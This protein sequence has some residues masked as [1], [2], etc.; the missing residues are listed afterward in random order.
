VL[1]RPERIP[2][3]DCGQATPSGSF[4]FTFYLGTEGRYEAKAD[5]HQ[6]GGGYEPPHT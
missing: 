3:R 1:R 6:A 2:R 5:L 4:Q